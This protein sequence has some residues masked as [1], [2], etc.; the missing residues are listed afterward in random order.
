MKGKMLSFTSRL[1]PDS[2]AFA[3]FITEKYEYKDKRGI[4]SDDVVKKINSFLRVLKVKKKEEDISSFDLSDQ[5]KCFAIR[6]KNKYSSY[7]PQENGGAFFSY[8]KKFKDIKK[9]RF[10]SR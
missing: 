8:L 6:V 3:I 5:Q 10:I 7:I 4:L 2:G 9:N 1:S